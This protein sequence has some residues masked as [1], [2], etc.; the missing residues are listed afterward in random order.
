MIQ[1]ILFHFSV[2]PPFDARH[3]ASGSS[4]SVSEETPHEE[5]DVSQFFSYTQPTQLTQEISEEEVL[6]F[7]PAAQRREIRPRDRYS[8][9]D[10]DRPRAPASARR[11]KWARGRG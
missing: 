3:A 8:P 4:H 6:P 2:P 7:G 1:Y 10:Y 9:A 11:P 5:L